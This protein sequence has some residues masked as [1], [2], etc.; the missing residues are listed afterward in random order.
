MCVEGTSGTG[1]E[2]D[3]IQEIEQ[4]MDFRNNQETVERGVGHV[5]A[6][7]QLHN[8]DTNHKLILE[9]DINDQI[10]QIYEVGLGQLARAD[11]GL[12]RHLV[13]QQLQLPLHTKRQW[14]ESINVAV[15]RKQLHEHGAMVGEQ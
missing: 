9:K 3:K 11:F 14:L 12:M 8:S 10:R 5:G 15:H 4:A 13:N 7:E 2:T 6:T 1:L